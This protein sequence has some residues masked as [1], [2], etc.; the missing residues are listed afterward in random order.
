MDDF[1]QRNREGEEL[2]RELLAQIIF[3]IEMLEKSVC[4]SGL[5]VVPSKRGDAKSYLIGRKHRLER[6]LGIAPQ[7]CRALARIQKRR[8]AW[9]RRDGGYRCCSTNNCC[10]KHRF[11]E[12]DRVPDLNLAA[13]AHRSRNTR[14]PAL[15]RLA[16]A[17]RPPLVNAKGSHWLFSLPT[18]LPAKPY[19]PSEGG[20][21]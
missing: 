18:A 2:D 19:L 17:V 6:T 9:L 15:R 14:P 5:S 3:A 7:G 8:S 4:L 11:S 20:S 12:I 13:M 1:Y 10:P 16:G 21:L